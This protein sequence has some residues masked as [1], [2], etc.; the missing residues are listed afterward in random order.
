[1]TRS[2]I[3]L[4]LLLAGCPGDIKDIIGEGEGE[5]E[6]ESLPSM[7]TE[8]TTVSYDDGELGKIEIDVDD[9]TTAFLITAEGEFYP[10]IEKVVDPDGDKV[11]DQ[12]DYYGED[13]FLTEAIYP[14]YNDMTFNWPIRSEDGKLS[15]GTWKVYLGS[16]NRSGFSKA[17]ELDVVIKTKRDSSFSS[18]K[19]SVR[20][21]Y[22]DG[23]MDDDEVVRGVEGAVDRWE[24]IWGLYDIE[25]DVEY[26]E[27]S[28]DADLS[29]PD[30]SDSEIDKLA[31]S[32]NGRQIT[33]IIGETIDGSSRDVYGV[34][35]GIP[36]PLTDTPRAAIVISWLANAGGDGEFSDDDIRLFGETLAHE[37]GHFMGLFHPV[38]YGWEYWDALDDTDHCTS[39]SK[40]EDAMGDNLMFPYPVCTFREC[41]A[42]EVMTDDQVGVKMRY[43]GNR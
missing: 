43:T 39:T 3:W 2:S 17:D 5:G 26:A 42:Q 25:L 30:G 19:T 11:F 20:I 4:V 24:E 12:S 29:S 28:I 38:E 35:G 34:T 41:V 31:R 15:E 14:W 27:S 36:A 9:E 22:A 33:L 8:E 6:G 18:G 23:M 40:C 16:Y 13:E 21:V 7:D 1:M 32:T 10:A 37:T